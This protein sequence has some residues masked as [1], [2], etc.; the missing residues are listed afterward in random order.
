MIVE[1]PHSAPKG[2]HYEVEEYDSKYLRIMLHH[3][4]KYDYNLGKPVATVWG[5]Y[6]RKTSKFHAPINAKKVGKVVSISETTP[7]TSMPIS[8]TPLEQAFS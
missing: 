2:Y 7:Y 1:L 6:A 4:R 3:H 5:F 8:I